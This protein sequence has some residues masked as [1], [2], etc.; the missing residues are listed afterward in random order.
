MNRK[1]YTYKILYIIY[2]NYN[3]IYKTIQNVI[4]YI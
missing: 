2:N 1:Y 4:E 3:T